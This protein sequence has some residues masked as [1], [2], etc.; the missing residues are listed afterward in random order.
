MTSFLESG[1]FG[2]KAWYKSWDGVQKTYQFGQHLSEEQKKK[3]VFQPVDEHA[4][5][6]I[7]ESLE[8]TDLFQE[9][10]NMGLKISMDDA[11]QAIAEKIEMNQAKE[12]MEKV[13]K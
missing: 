7:H 10:D 4:K 8:K 6:M 12:T 2:R 13:E 11:I 1:R 5:H 9:L 3:L